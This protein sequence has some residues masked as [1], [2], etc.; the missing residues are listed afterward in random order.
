MIFVPIN[1]VDGKYDF[2]QTLPQIKFETIYDCVHLGL[3]TS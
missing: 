3:H 1:I 2:L